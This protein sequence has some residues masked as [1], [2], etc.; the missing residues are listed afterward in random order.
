V[1]VTIKW[2]YAGSLDDVAQLAIR[3]ALFDR[4]QFLDEPVP[5]RGSTLPIM[6]AAGP[7]GL[8][9]TVSRRAIDGRDFTV[10]S[11]TR[12]LV[13]AEAGEF[14][15]PPIHVAI[16]KVT[17]WGRDLFMER[18]PVST[19]RMKAVGEPLR[20]VVRV[21]PLAD[22]PAGF[23]GVVGRGMSVEVRADRS[24]VRVGDPI[25]LTVTNPRR[26]RSAKRPRPALGAE[27]GLDPAQ[28]RVPDTEVPGVLSDD[29]GPRPSPFPCGSCASRWARFRGS[30]M[31]GS[32]R[33][34]RRSRAPA[35]TRS[36]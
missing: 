9:A 5:P 30:A 4:F 13:L 8:G 33:S 24:V 15:I 16:D 14:D 27:G 18:R 32:T 31:S 21:P 6:T 11:A 35:P 20:L 7:V 36:P 34:S 1:P 19:V 10:V 3:S 17:R 2:C 12:R 26:C 22:A 28:F 29:G 23:S 25:T